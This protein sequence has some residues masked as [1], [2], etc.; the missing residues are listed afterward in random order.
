MDRYVLLRK[1][2]EGSF[3]EVLQAQDTKNGQVVAIKKFKRSDDENRELN[4]REVRAL[5][6]LRGMPNIITL[7]DVFTEGEDLCLVFEFMKG[8]LLSEMQANPTGMPPERVR[9]VTFQMLRALKSCHDQGILHRDVK[10]EN[11]LLNEAG[12]TIKLC[13]FGCARK[14]KKRLEMTEYVATRWYRAPELHLGTREY[15][16]P[17]DLWAVGC[18]FAEMV[19]GKPLF[20]CKDGIDGLKLIQRCVGLH[21]AIRKELKECGGRHA[22]GL[23]DTRPPSGLA[24]RFRGVLPS[25]AMDFLRGLLRSDPAQ[26]MTADQAL[27]HDYLRPLLI[28]N[29]TAGA[30]VSPR[31]PSGRTKKVSPVAASSGEAGDGGLLPRLPKRKEKRKKEEKGGGSH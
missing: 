5:K 12:T 2:G 19:D 13:D 11:V 28:Q 25:V 26:R 7:L 10:P 1:V 15:G 3:G 23:A 16:F 31:L 18:I 9:L 8:N 6:R 24:E 17:V 22:E 27:H 4:L 14:M 29:P 20:P 21:P 30:L